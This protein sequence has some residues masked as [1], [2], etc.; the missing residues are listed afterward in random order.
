MQPSALLR[1]VPTPCPGHGEAGGPAGPR[2]GPF[3]LP[4]AGTLPSASALPPGLEPLPR[5]QFL[6]G[7]ILPTI[8][9]NG[10]KVEPRNSAHTFSALNSH[11]AHRGS[12]VLLGQTNIIPVSRGSQAAPRCTALGTSHQPPGKQAHCVST[13]AS[14][15][16]RR[17]T[18]DWKS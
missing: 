5:S 13:A 15:G 8:Q 3:G 11:E 7:S 14:P 9:K 16:P 18:K 12:T 10:T 2:W 1:P 4:V 17:G 6:F